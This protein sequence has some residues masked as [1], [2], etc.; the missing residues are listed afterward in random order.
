MNISNLKKYSVITLNQMF[1]LLFSIYLAYILKVIL[2]LITYSFVEDIYLDIISYSSFLIL[3]CVIF[4]YLLTKKFGA[5][6]QISNGVFCFYTGYFISYFSMTIIYLVFSKIR[7]FF[8]HSFSYHNITELPRIL[9]L[10]AAIFFG[11]LLFTLIHY[12]EQKEYI[13][14]KIPN[15]AYKI[16]FIL[17]LHSCMLFTLMSFAADI[18]TF[19]EN[20]VWWSLYAFLPS[21]TYASLYVNKYLAYVLTIITLHPIFLIVAQRIFY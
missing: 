17:I 3:S 21:A 10:I 16:I 12:L 13:K 19:R 2:I 9:I 14:I 15:Y 18:V 7:S 4:Y 11:F 5:F 6:Q 1:N 20:F 8:D